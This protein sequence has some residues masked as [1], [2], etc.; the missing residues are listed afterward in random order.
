MGAGRGIPPRYALQGTRNTRE[1]GERHTLW[2]F[3]TREA[4]RYTRALGREVRLFLALVTF[5]LR[6]LIFTAAEALSLSLSLSLARS[7]FFSERLTRCLISDLS[8]GNICSPCRARRSRI[9]EYRETRRMAFP[10][11]LPLRR[12]YIRANRRVPVTGI[13]LSG[14][15]A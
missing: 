4:G 8:K 7:L 11:L 15:R 10:R 13:G 6:A 14:S 9:H 5:S 12:S 3:V 2:T 1:V